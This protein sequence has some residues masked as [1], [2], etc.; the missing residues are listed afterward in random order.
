[1]SC[2]DSS[3]T[4]PG[5][6]SSNSLYRS[7]GGSTIKVHVAI[8]KLGEQMFAEMDSQTHRLNALVEEVVDALAADSQHCAGRYRLNREV[9]WTTVQ[10]VRIACHYLVFERK[11]CDVLAVVVEVV[12]Y[13]FEVSFLHE[14]K[15]LCCFALFLQSFARIVS[16][17]LAMQ[18]AVVVYL[19]QVHV[20]V[21][22]LLHLALLIFS[23]QSYAFS[24]E[25]SGSKR[26]IN[27]ELSLISVSPVVLQVL[28]D[29]VGRHSHR[30]W[31][32]RG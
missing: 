10:Q 2:S 6:R 18:F 11:P 27:E 16:H 32:R 7:G 25:H 24:S 31:C 15:P 29:C 9:R 8:L 22:S 20:V 23:A 17:S 28:Q 5:H 3:L 4:I 13:V 30:G 1:M 21:V 26:F 19:L 12:G 14:G